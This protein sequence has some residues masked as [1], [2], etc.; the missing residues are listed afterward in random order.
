MIA[1][2]VNPYNDEPKAA[3]KDKNKK[4]FIEEVE[5]LLNQT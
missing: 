3:T 5:R 4:I 2:A 1:K